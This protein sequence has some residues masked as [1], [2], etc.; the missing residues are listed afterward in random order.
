[1]R[2][3][4]T[5]EF[6]STDQIVIHWKRALLIKFGSFELIKNNTIQ[7]TETLHTE[8][9]DI[10]FKENRQAFDNC[11]TSEYQGERERINDN[12]PY[13]AASVGLPAYINPSKD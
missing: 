1:V 12:R 2:H 7:L 8:S 10:E 13:F 9:R 4:H 11:G 6:V 5:L 3:G